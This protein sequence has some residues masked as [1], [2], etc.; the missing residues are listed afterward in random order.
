VAVRL[1]HHEIACMLRDAGAVDRWR[2]CVLS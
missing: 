2:C 1:G